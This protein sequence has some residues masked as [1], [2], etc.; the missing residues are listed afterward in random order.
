MLNYSTLLDR[1]NLGLGSAV[2]VLLFVFVGI[3]RV[4]VH[5]GVRRRQPARPGSRA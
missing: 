1:L 3:D 5:Q 4:R 2:S